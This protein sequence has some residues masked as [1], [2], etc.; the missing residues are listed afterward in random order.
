MTGVGCCFDKSGLEGDVR[1]VKLRFLR[2]EL[3]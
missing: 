2:M 3:L 1:T